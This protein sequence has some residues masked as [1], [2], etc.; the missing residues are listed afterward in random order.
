MSLDESILKINFKLWDVYQEKLI[1]NKNISG[2]SASDWRI[3]SHIISNLIY[4]SITGEKGYFDTKV[5]YIAEEGEGE[6]KSKKLAIMDYDG[7]NHKILVSGGIRIDLI[8]IV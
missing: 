8:I 5:V 4:E 7:N 2:I 1:L 3:S 6:K